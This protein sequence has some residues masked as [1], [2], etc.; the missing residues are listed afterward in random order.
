MVR[1][2]HDLRNHLTVIVGYGEQLEKL[3]TDEQ[4]RLKA[5]VIVQAGQKCNEIVASLLEPR[6]RESRFDLNEVVEALQLPMAHGI[7]FKLE[8]ADRPL[9]MDG[10][11]L[12]LYRA[13]LNLCVNAKH[14]MIGTPD[15]ELRIATRRDCGYAMVIVQDT[16]AGMDDATLS[17]LWFRPIDSRGHGHGLKIVRS[18]ID[19]F[20]G[21]IA[22]QSMVGLG[23]TFTIRL[24]LF[25]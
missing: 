17:D 20:D 16:G 24:P 21:D 2:A 13:L 12:L 1:A 4:S 23:T 18:T 3:L 11:S 10:D 15:D 14:A 25:S 5:R 7:A 8:L 22:V 19:Q 6:P 9:I